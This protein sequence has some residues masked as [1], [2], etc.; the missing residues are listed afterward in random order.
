MRN[1][2]R[3][4]IIFVTLALSGAA[5]L[6]FGVQRG[7]TAGRDDI[8]DVMSAV[9]FATLVCSTLYLLLRVLPTAIGR[10]RLQ[11]GAG[12]ITQWQVSAADWDKFRALDAERAGADP[13]F[14]AND[15]WIRR[16]TPPEGVE[17]I[18]GKK[19]LIVDGSYHPLRMNGI[20]E[21]RSIG[22]LDNAP[23][24][25]RPPDCLEFLLAYP[26][27]RYGGVRYTCLRVPVPEA[28]RAR[29]LSAYRH[30]A[31][32]LEKRRAKGAIALRNPRR[33]YQI[34]AALFG[35]G[36]VAAVAGAVMI[37][38]ARS[39]GEYAGM[40]AGFLTLGGT[41]IAI[42]SALVGGMTFLLRWKEGKDSERR[43][44]HRTRK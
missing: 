35:V 24:P 15:L 41:F 32:A 42:P 33:T 27:G 23:R 2:H 13:M 34:T 5:L 36:L 31:P 22:W 40:I 43:L 4:A 21:L 12:R 18:V 9:G 29:G 28:A 6:W 39:Q 1:P 20:P 38:I 10:A 16:Q 30:F 8:S 25:G 14:L 37:A 19:A 7:N 17:I 11:A 26:A 44:N 3:K